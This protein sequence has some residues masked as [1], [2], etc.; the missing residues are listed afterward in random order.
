MNLPST[1]SQES[2]LFFPFINKCFYS[3]REI[4]FISF[5][6][7]VLNLSSEH[8]GKFGEEMPSN[9]CLPYLW[10]SSVSILSY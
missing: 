3:I 1:L 7:A 6:A 2:L 4:G 8:L 10:A 5:V 9:K